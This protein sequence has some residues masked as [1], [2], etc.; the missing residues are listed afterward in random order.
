[1]CYAI[2]MWKLEVFV[3][4]LTDITYPTIDR[5]NYEG[6]A[7]R[8]EAEAKIMEFWDKRTDTVG[9]TFYLI[10]PWGNVFPVDLFPEIFLDITPV[11][12]SR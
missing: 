5:I 9:F 6:F 12:Y 3:K 2:S 8:A 4:D 1:M 10:A 11:L 7:S